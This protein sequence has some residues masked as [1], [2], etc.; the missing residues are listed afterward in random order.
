[1]LEPTA[2]PKGCGESA[3]QPPLKLRRSAETLGS[4][5]EGAERRRKLG[6]TTAAPMLPLA[7]RQLRD[8]ENTRGP[9]LHAASDPAGHRT[10]RERLREALDVDPIVLPNRPYLK[11]SIIIR[12]FATRG[13]LCSYRT[14]VPSDD[15]ETA[16]GP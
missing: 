12:S 13:L 2:S 9:S 1:V 10:R 14:T 15:I 6:P 3:D 11:F 4:K 16:L 7:R 8:T 5:A